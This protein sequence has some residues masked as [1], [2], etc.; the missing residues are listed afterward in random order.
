MS[1]ALFKTYTRKYLPLFAAPNIRSVVSSVVH[2]SRPSSELKG[3]GRLEK[4]PRRMTNGDLS[5]PGEYRVYLMTSATLK[6][7]VGSGLA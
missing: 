3:G 2:E 5:S 6:P 4:R 1:Y 7:M